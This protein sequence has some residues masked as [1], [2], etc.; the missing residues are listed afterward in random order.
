MKIRTRNDFVIY[1]HYN[2]YNQKIRMI[3]FVEIDNFKLLETFAAVGGPEL[4]NLLLPVKRNRL[5]FLATS[6]I[7]HRKDL[8]HVLLLAE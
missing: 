6:S 3:A 2:C 8:C 7:A 1:A 5:S 4:A